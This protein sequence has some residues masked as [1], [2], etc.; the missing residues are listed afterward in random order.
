MHWPLNGNAEGSENPAKAR[1]E[2][3][4]CAN[5][6]LSA[7]V[8]R[9]LLG[10]GAMS[11]RIWSMM[12]VPV[13]FTLALCWPTVA[14]SDPGGSPVCNSGAPGSVPGV[15]DC[16]PSADPAPALLPY[17]SVPY[18]LLPDTAAV[19][20]KSWQCLAN[21]VNPALDDPV[22][23]YCSS[24]LQLAPDLAS[25][26]GQRWVCPTVGSGPIPPPPPDPPD[27]R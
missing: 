11:P 5:L 18:M 21:G 4:P 13:F 20:G 17:C 14:S 23:P 2:M 1:F 26:G 6:S 10:R 25:L 24:P 3:C 8:Q 22:L 16:P 12:S 7:G 15:A 27:L 19:G 9:P